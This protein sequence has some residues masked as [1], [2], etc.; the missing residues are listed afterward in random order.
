[1]VVGFGSQLTIQKRF[2]GVGSKSRATKTHPKG[3]LA[4][5]K[6]RRRPKPPPSLGRKR[7]RCSSPAKLG[8]CV[9]HSR[10][11]VSAS[12]HNCALHHAHRASV[13]GCPL[14]LPEQACCRSSPR[15]S[16]ILASGKRPARFGMF[17][18]PDRMLFCCAARS[19]YDHRSVDPLGCPR[20][21]VPR[22]FRGSSQAPVRPPDGGFLTISGRKGT[23]T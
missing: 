15:T 16:Q 10:Q 11:F 14:V 22:C 7:P 6:K 3:P 13:I 8:C 21:R 19:R 9:G 4:L 12:Q 20:R 2:E 1:M 23:S 18:R 5:P 17:E